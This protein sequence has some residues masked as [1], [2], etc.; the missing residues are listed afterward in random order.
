V[1]T[2][3]TTSSASI[4]RRT[5]GYSSHD[6]RHQVELSDASARVVDQLGFERDIG[7]MAQRTFVY[8]GRSFFF[9]LDDAESETA[10]PTVDDGGA[11]CFFNFTEQN[12][13][14]MTQGAL[15]NFRVGVNILLDQNQCQTAFFTV[16]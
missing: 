5:V 11:V 3:P 13:L 15:V 9:A 12:I 8:F 1:K 10:C 4:N 6:E 2:R 7:A 16:D 14:A